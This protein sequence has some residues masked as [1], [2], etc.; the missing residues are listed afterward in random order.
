VADVTPEQLLAWVD[1]YERAWRAPGTESLGELFADQAEYLVTPYDEPVW[2]VRFAPDGRA[3][4]FEEWPFWPTHGKSPQS[5]SPAVRAAGAVDE[6][7][8][9]RF[10]DVTDDLEVSVIF[11][12]P[13]SAD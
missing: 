10:V 2:V 11:A 6:Q 4:R 7:S 1:G 9:H 5:G 3:E 13:E 12:P 8:P